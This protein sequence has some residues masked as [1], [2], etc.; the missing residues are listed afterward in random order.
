M[1]KKL[2]EKKK[3]I[4]SVTII[5][6]DDVQENFDAIRKTEKGIIISRLIQ[7]DGKKDYIECGFIP[8]YNIKEVKRN[9]D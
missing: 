8:N 5:Y 3:L 9:N 2:P 4:T 1:N 6:L 7:I